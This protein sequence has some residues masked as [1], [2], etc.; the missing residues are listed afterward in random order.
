MAGLQP[1]ME[2]VELFAYQLLD[3]KGLMTL[4]EKIEDLA[5]V[6]RQYFLYNFYTQ[7]VEYMIIY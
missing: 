2:M 3:V 1:T 4:L 7:K 6:D 5:C